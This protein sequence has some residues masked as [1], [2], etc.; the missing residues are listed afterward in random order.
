MTF[1]YERDPYPTWRVYVFIG[2]LWRWAEVAAIL[3]THIN[4]IDV[5][6]LGVCV[7]VSVPDSARPVTWKRITTAYETVIYETCHKYRRSS[8]GALWPRLKSRGWS[9]DGAPRCLLIPALNR[10][11]NQPCITCLHIASVACVSQDRAH[12]ILY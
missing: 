4:Y 8:T 7:S 3:Q 10:G 1:I 9:R 12:W 11:I 2:M 5:I 6:S